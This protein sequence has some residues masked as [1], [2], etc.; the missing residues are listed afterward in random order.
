MRLW[1]RVVPVAAAA[2]LTASTAAAAQAVA[3]AAPE[4]AAEAVT[5][6]S[7]LSSRT[8]TRMGVLFAFLALIIL[9]WH[10]DSDEPL[11]P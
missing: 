11:S 4:P 3:P 9:I 7:A 8:A 2:M 10:D 5:E 6:G 1:K